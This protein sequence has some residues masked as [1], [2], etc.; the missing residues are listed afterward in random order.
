M[1][2][3]LTPDCL[4]VC[5]A[6]FL[7]HA[8]VFVVCP[9][10]P[11]VMAERLSLPVSELGWGFVLFAAGCVAVGPLNAHLCDAYKRKYVFMVS[12]AALAACWLAMA[13]ADSKALYMLLMIAAGASYGLAL[14]A[15]ITVSI[16]IT[17]SRR[18][19]ET[20]R[21]FALAACTGMLVGT[22]IGVGIFHLWGF[23]TCLY[24]AAGALAVALL[25]VSTVRVAFRAPLGVRLLNVDRF[26]LPRAWVLFADVSI[27]CFA[28]GL[29]VPLTVNNAVY[30][31]V[32]LALLS[33]VIM[34]VIRMFVKM[35]H[36]CQRGTANTTC[37]QAVCIGL[38]L[39]MAC[40]FT[41]MDTTAILQTSIA[42]AVVAVALFFF[43]A[44]PYFRKKRVRS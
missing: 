21:L 38:M 41:I 5:I 8:A 37:Y 1:L 34:P 18:R 10:L 29:L 14:T 3:L 16:D 17:E 15:G 44:L 27:F 19:S 7:M 6:C 36:H 42:V 33:A 9:L 4:R 28:V 22:G 24:S 31:L 13:A 35:S 40:A 32:A 43:A 39:G 11:F 20:N 26:F 2:R 30:A 25:L 23:R 12:A